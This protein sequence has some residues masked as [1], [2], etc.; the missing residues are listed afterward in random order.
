MFQDTHPHVF[1]Y[2]WFGRRLRGSH[3]W[4]LARTK[5]QRLYG[6][7]F[8]LS[9]SFHAWDVVQL[10]RSLPRRCLESHTVTAYSLPAPKYHAHNEHLDI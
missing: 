2:H 4:R 6:Q 1:Q 5:D 9:R 10:V 3:A 8:T 7:G